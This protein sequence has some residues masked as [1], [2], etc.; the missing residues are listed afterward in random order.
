MAGTE[1]R[2][3]RGCTPQA[4]AF[5]DHFNDLAA[6]GVD[7]IFGVSTQTTEYQKEAAD[8]LHLPF[9]LLSDSELELQETLGLPTLSVTIPEQN[10]TLLKRLALIIRENRIVKCF[11]P[12]FPPERNAGDVLAWLEEN[13]T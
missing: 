2:V 5:R 8:R 6:L 1:Y 7:Q 11:Y 12:V 10:N 9:P 13:Q 3:P 4:C